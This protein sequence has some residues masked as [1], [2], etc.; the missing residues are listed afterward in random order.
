[1]EFNE[2]KTAEYV[3]YSNKHLNP[4]FRHLFT[5][6]YEIFSLVSAYTHDMG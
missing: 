5:L 3:L 2:L 4:V 6:K 1:M